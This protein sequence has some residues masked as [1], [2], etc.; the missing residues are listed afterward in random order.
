MMISRDQGRLL[1]PVRPGFVILSITIATIL[2]IHFVRNMRHS[3]EK[4]CNFC[5]TCTATEVV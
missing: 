1:L 5:R 3:F 4:T 2:Q